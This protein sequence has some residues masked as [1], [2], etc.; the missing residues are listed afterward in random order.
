MYVVPVLYTLDDTCTCAT[1]YYHWKF[2]MNTQACA[3]TLYK[4]Y[5]PYIRI[6]VRYIYI[7]I[8]TYMYNIIVSN[9]K[10]MYVLYNIN[11]VYKGAIYGCLKKIQDLILTFCQSFNIVGTCDRTIYVKVYKMLYT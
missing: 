6:Y 7:Y 3:G 11:T 2:K 5:Y 8:C 1:R 10:Y 9:I 4:L